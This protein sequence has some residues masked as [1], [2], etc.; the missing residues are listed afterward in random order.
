MTFL[1]KWL[2]L[3]G[4]PTF[5]NLRKTHKYIRF[6]SKWVFK[7]DKTHFPKPQKNPLVHRF[8]LKWVLLKD[9]TH[10]SKSKENLQLQNLHTSCGPFWGKHT[11]TRTSTH[12]NDY[13]FM[14]Q[15]NILK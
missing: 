9:K 2:L 10:F 3:K 1:S 13:L 12:G 5:Q 6:L 7:W 14:E 4:K 11:C 8:F 15:K